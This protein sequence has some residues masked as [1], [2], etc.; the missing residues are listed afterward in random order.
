MDGTEPVLYA[1]ILFLIDFC[2]DY[3]SL[4]ATGKLLSLPMALGRTLLASL[5]GGVYGVFSVFIG[6]DGWVGAV[7]AVG[8]SMLMTLVSFGVREGVRGVCRTALAVWGVGALLGGVMTAVSGIFGPSS[9]ELTGGAGGMLC[10]VLVVLM[11]LTRF[12]RQSFT[13]GTAEIE[14]TENGNCWKGT[15]LL[16]SGN[17]LTDPLSGYPV[18]LLRR[19]AALTLLGEQADTL[20]RGNIPEETRGIRAVPVR[21]VKGMRILYG[22]LGRDITLR[23]GKRT[24]CRCAVVCVDHDTEDFGGCDAL[25]PVSLMI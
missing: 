15:G 3:L 23:R 11:G 8:V 14:I 19:P 16:D 13:K 25:L 5:L 1:D 20:Y 21:T 10:G 18:V 17:L 4:Y 24:W 12:V 7:L 9:G 6:L 2:M 22:F